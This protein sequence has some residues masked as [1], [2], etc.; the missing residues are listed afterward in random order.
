VIPSYMFH[1]GLDF[2]YQ[3]LYLSL[4]TIFLPFFC[5]LCLCQFW[6]GQFT[7][8]VDAEILIRIGLRYRDCFDGT[9]EDL[10]DA[11]LPLP[12]DIG[13]VEWFADLDRRR[14]LACMGLHQLG[15][16]SAHSIRHSPLFF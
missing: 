5:S 2:S 6:I 3:S 4:S 7:L 12:L 13:M 1:W 14:L 16:I 8:I 9:H 11:V 10:V 15:S